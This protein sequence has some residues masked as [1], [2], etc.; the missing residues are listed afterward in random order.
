METTPLTFP[1]STHTTQKERKMGYIHLLI[2]TNQKSHQP[3]Q[4]TGIKNS[5]QKQQY[6]GPLNQNNNQKN[7]TTQ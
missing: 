5:I 4:E 6:T 7:P 3:T 2:P 1:H